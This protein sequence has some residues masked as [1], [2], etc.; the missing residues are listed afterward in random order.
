M[1]SYLIAHNQISLLSDGNKAKI[2]LTNSLQHDEKQDGIISIHRWLQKEIACANK[3]KRSQKITCVIGNP[4]Y[5]GRDKDY[6]KNAWIDNLLRRNY[7]HFLEDE[8]Q[9]RGLKDPYIK[10]ILLGQ[11]L[12]Q[13]GKDSNSDKG[14]LA[15]ITNNSFLDGP[16]HR[17]MRWKLL[18]IF[19]KIYIFNLHGN[20][21]NDQKDENVF[22]IKSVGISINVFIRT[23]ETIENLGKVYYKEL[24]GKRKFKLEYL[25]NNDFDPS[26]FQ[27]IKPS[28]DMYYFIPDDNENLNYLD[29][30]KGF[31]ISELFDINSNGIETAQDRLTIHFT[32][33]SLDEVVDDFIRNEP[34]EL[35]TMYANKTINGKRGFY[36]GSNWTF[37]NARQSLMQN[38]T[39][40][41]RIIYR[42]FDFRYTK[43]HARNS[44]FLHFTANKT[45]KHLLVEGN[46][47][48]LL[49]RQSKFDFSYSFVVDQ[50][51]GAQVF[52]TKNAKTQVF[53][54]YTIS[55]FEKDKLEPNFNHSI[56]KIVENSL[57]INFV[58]EKENSKNQAQFTSIDIFDYIYAILHS[59]QYRGK[60]GV[61][62]RRSF[63][64]VPY[65]KDIK[66]FWYL[67]EKGQELRNLHLLKF[68]YPAP[69][70]D[71][72]LS[73]TKLRN[74]IPLSMRNKVTVRFI[75]KDPGYEPITPEFGRV[76]INDYQY[77]NKVPKNAFN[78]IIGNNKP[79]LRYLQERRGRKLDYRE[80]IHYQKLIF[81]LYESN[82]IMKELN[83][84]EIG[85]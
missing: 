37:R 30:E 20:L 2:Y 54:L 53:P 43:Y 11:D 81:A 38:E 16:I 69:S 26:Y 79:A 78:F 74:D 13:K 67:V 58:D 34:Y 62:L 21:G 55:P 23:G 76:Y 3:V 33:E 56:I 47:A 46:I 82:K 72:V 8:K 17:G 10:F 40:T 61:Y 39:N 28:K 9:T 45:M 14:I 36:E 70:S 4:P 42:P 35:K 75:K 18:T 64:R 29:G 65:P 50:M 7:Y 19:N 73:F 80:I 22:K 44:G 41:H 85:F 66:E 83:N 71:L 6:N 27:E 12:I 60:Y 5:G 57:D 63:P 49:K 68:N 1:V 24:I 32:E 84:F 48:L 51:C 77:F 15:Y 31:S 59:P 25:S 52:E